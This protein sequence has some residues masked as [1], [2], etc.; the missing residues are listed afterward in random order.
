MRDF[1]C[2]YKFSRVYQITPGGVRVTRSAHAA[3]QGIVTHQAHFG[4]GGWA[5]RSTWTNIS[6]NTGVVTEQQAILNSDDIRGPLGCAHVANRSVNPCSRIVQPIGHER[7][8]K[9]T[10]IHNP[11]G[12]E[13][14]KVANATY[15]LGL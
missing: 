2:Q 12:G 4:E 15:T 6:T 10:R 9:I 3:F 14:L 13:L 7:V 8:T 1:L 11:G 5:S